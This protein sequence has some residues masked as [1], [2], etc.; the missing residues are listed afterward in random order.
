MIEN[1]TQIQCCKKVKFKI[2]YKKIMHNMPSS[3][4]C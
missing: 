1:D 4:R 3:E 2:L